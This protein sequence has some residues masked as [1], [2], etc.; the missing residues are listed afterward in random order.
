[1]GGGVLTRGSE[2]LLELVELSLKL[3]QLRP[4][5][6]DLGLE[7]LAVG[8]GG[9]GCGAHDACSTALPANGTPARAVAPAR[10]ATPITAP[11][12][13]NAHPQRSTRER[14]LTRSR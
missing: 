9:G 5:V 4:E 8:T 12:G 2:L 14:S 6:I 10:S 3:P 1:G 11:Q 7:A 13:V